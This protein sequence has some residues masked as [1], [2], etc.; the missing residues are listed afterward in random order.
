MRFKDPGPLFR[1][2]PIRATL[3]G[4]KKFFIKLPFLLPFTNH[5]TKLDADKIEN[6]VH[7]KV[8]KKAA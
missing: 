8:L 7:A 6:Q 4:S 1:L 5:N 2:I 3:S